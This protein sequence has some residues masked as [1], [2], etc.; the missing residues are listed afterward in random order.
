MGH[1]I[2]LQV[3]KGWLFTYKKIALDSDHKLIIHT[4]EKSWNKI[5]SESLLS[6]PK[7]GSLIPSTGVIRP[8]D[9]PVI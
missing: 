9:R 1:F 3:T 7:E 4:L 5:H 6:N 2:F 8:G